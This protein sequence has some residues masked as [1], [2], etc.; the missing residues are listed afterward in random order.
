MPIVRARERAREKAKTT[1][2]SSLSNNL[3]HRN[4]T[5][6][7]KCKNC[8]KGAKKA[9]PLLVREIQVNNVSNPNSL[10][11]QTEQSTGQN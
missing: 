3:H 4:G 7:E 2:G 9:K 8:S 11:R 10:N 5:R 1:D 6:Q